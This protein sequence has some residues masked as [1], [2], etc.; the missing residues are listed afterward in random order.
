MINTEFQTFIDF[1][2]KSISE[3]TFI[4]ITFSKKRNQNLDLKNVFI[5]LIELKKQTFLSFV[6][7]SSFNDITKNLEIE[8][9]IIEIENLFKTNF[10]IINLLT[11][12][13]NIELKTNKKNIPKIIIKKS[14]FLQVPD[15]NHDN[16]KNRKIDLSKNYLKKLGITNSE[17]TLIKNM[18]DKY[19][20]IEKFIEIFEN[21]ISNTKPEEKIKIVDMGAGKGYL[22]FSLY[23]YLSNIQSYN[24]EIKGIETQQKLV[25]ICNQI[26]Q[27]EN[28]TNLSFEKNTIENYSNEKIDILIAL[29]A[30]DTATDDAIYKGIKSNAQIIIVAPC[31]HKQIR[32]QINKQNILSSVTKHG[33]L[34]E[35]QAEILTDSLRALILEQNSYKSNVFEFISSEHTG[36]NLMI[37]AIK[38]N[39]SEKESKYQEIEELKKYFGIEYHYLEKLLSEEDGDWKNQNPIC[40]L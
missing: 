9:G 36:K 10:L 26:A 28:F 21:L 13:K 5:K 24:I 23:D 30:C 3:N 37:T 31:C 1:F 29:H 35:R 11:T 27:E 22:T 17:G 33:I 6:Y 34:L 8:E 16:K 39:K 32:K 25:D 38:T 20:Q 12:E 40:N 18:S 14:R 7:R 15:K 4:K 19:R 2:R